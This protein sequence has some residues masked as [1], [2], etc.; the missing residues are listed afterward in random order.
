MKKYSAYI[1]RTTYISRC[2]YCYNAQ[3]DTQ[4]IHYNRFLQRLIGHLLD[5]QPRAFWLSQAGTSIELNG[6]MNWYLLC[7]KMQVWQE[8]A[9]AFVPWSFIKNKKGHV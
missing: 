1:A 7:G 2:D 9:A 5:W 4:N 8:A 6:H 3:R